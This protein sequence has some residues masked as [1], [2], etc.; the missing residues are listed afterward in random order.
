MLLISDG[1]SCIGCVVGQSASLS[2]ETEIN[3]HAG[4]TTASVFFA[5]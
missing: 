1:V 3:R 2:R 5:A 4:V